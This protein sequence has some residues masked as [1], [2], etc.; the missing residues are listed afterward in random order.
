MAVQPLVFQRR[1][2]EARRVL[3]NYDVLRR[4]Q[5]CFVSC[6]K[7]T[8]HHPVRREAGTRGTYLGGGTRF[9]SLSRYQQPLLIFLVSLCLGQIW[10]MKYFSTTSIYQELQIGHCKTCEGE[11]VSLSDLLI[12]DA[13][14]K[15]TDGTLKEAAVASSQVI[16]LVLHI[17]RCK[18]I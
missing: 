3:M 12:Y 13:P 18:R 15:C 8:V 11:E 17:Q 2:R 1:M 4:C 10:R 9:E 14:N 16:A 6:L 7:V 5:E